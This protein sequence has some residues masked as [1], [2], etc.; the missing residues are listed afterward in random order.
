MALKDRATLKNYFKNGEQPTEVNFAHLIDSTVNQIDDGFAKTDKEGLELS[1]HS[2]SDRILSFFQKIG[3]KSASWAIKLNKP[4]Q[5][6]TNTNEALNITSI[7]LD[8]KNVLTLTKGEKVG[9]N[10]PSPKYDLDVKNWIASKGRIGTYGQHNEVLADGN[11][12]SI[13]ER[14]SYCQGFEVVART[15]VKAT[16]KHAL[17]HA[18][19]LNAFGN[20]RTKVKATNIQYSFWRPVKIELRW[21]LLDRNNFEYVLQIR[22]KQNL[23]NETYIKYYITQLWDDEAMGIEKQFRNV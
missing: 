2:Q 14:L 18:I 13:T 17:M 6:D 23:G 15:G 12:Y 3:D 10:N 21:L 16:G 5:A 9:I 22:C 20:G 4:D 11:W 1:N 8:D 7:G 19:A